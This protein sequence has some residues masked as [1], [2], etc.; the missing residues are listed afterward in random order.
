MLGLR[1]LAL[2]FSPALVLA[3][4]AACSSSTTAAAP[5]GDKPAAPVWEGAPATLAVYDGRVAETAIGIRTSDPTKLTVTATS[6]GIDTEVAPA[7]TPSTDGVWHGTLRVRPGYALSAD[8]PPSVTVEIAD[9]AGQHVT[10]RIALRVH[11]LGWQKRVTWTAPNGP[12]TREH[13]VFFYDAEAKAAFLFQGSGYAPQLTPLADAWRFDLATGAWSAWAPTGDLPVA[14]GSRR[15]A[16]IPG[17]KKFY[18]YGGYIGF[19]A[20]ANDDGNLSRIDLADAA[21]TFTR[22]T[23]VGAAPARELHAV[24]Y[25]AKGEQL[26]VFGGATTKPTQDVVDDTWS[27]KVSADTATWTQLKTAKSPTARYGSFTAFD[28]PSRRF[29]VWS[30]AQIPDV[31]SDPV[32]AAQDA[33]ALD[34]SVDPPAWSKLAPA[35]E[36]PKG[37]RNGCSMPDPSGRRLFVYGGTS[38][39][40]T[41][42]KGLFVLDLEPGHEAWTRLDLA[43]PPPLRSSGFGFATEQGEVTCSFGNDNKPMSDVAFLGYA[44]A[45][46]K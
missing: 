44:E 20:T 46:P 42:E 12:E 18:A 25:D 39:G 22:L 28:A 4:A 38:D 3:L 32:N 17:T 5:G 36:A 40:K 23:N 37:R 29:V 35:G 41:T 9:A 1:P 21:H 6:D 27:V 19:G 10:Q 34:L 16:S 11:K 14:G 15:I 30:G 45:P 24:A 43:S 7:E 8:A 26:I 33:W 13:G 2:A 31:A